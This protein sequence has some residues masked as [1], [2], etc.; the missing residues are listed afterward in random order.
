MNYT[1]KSP[2]SL[3]GTILPQTYS[4][5]S[6]L[7]IFCNYN[8]PKT[9]INSTTQTI[10]DGD[11]DDDGD[12]VDGLY[13]VHFKILKEI[14]DKSLVISVLCSK[15]CTLFSRIRSFINI[16]LI[17]SSGAMTILNS[18]NETDSGSIKYT[19]I[20]INSITATILSLVSNFKLAERELTY[21]QTH[22]RMKNMYHR[23]DIILRA[24][25][26]KINAESVGNITKEYVNIYEQLEYPIPHFVIWQLNKGLETEA[27]AKRKNANQE[28]QTIQ[29][30][31]DD[32][33]FNSQLTFTNNLNEYS[34]NNN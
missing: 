3:N 12:D 34:E 31:Y 20:I 25:P 26:T 11:D 21:K 16:P 17:L 15:S 28:E 14:K 30:E 24:E 2:E 10:D 5:N 9:L 7:N 19:N 33:L 1:S 32:V 18:M 22:K 23:V 4:N 13:N 6:L 29:V 8:I 27:V